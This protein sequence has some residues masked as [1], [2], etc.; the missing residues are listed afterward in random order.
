MFGRF[1]KTSYLCGQNQQF[2]TMTE[3]NYKTHQIAWLKVTDY[4]HAWLQLELGGGARIG[5]QRVVS[6]QHLPGSRTVLRMETRDDMADPGKVFN[7]MS[8]NRRNC[9][10]TGLDLDRDTVEQAYGVTADQLKLFVPL[11]CPKTCMTAL[12]VLRPWTP[13][14]S[15]GKEQA[16]AMQRLLRHEFW[17]AVDEF[18]LRYARKMNGRKYPQVDMIEAFCQETGTPDIY[19]DAMRREWQRRVKRGETTSLKPTEGPENISIFAL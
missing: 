10:V 8:S 16:S 9:V 18:N 3:K 14:V 5:D 1:P 4:M 13:N 15:F 7:A 19:V 11:E 2:M 17:R 12:G 6:I